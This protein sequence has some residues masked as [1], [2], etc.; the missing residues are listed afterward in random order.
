MTPATAETLLVTLADLLEA[1]E[2][3]SL[4]LDAGDVEAERVLCE[5]QDLLSR[6]L[7]RPLFVE[8]VTEPVE[9]FAGLAYSPLYGGY[10]LFLRSVY[11]AA[12]DADSAAMVAAVAPDGHSVYVVATGLL[13]YWGGYRAARHV[14]SGATGEQVNLRDQDGLADLDTLPPL[15]P[16][17]IRQAITEGAMFTLRRLRSGHV[18]QTTVEIDVGTQSRT[19]QRADPVRTLHDIFHTHAASYRA[20]L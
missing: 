10:Q 2:A 11:V 1:D 14:L 20:L 6:W 15:V 8:V 3:S 7:R 4:R 12:A 16:H 18:G 9:S 13:R 5:T 19:V 17:P